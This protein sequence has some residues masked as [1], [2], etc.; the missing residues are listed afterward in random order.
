M[1]G[2][3]LILQAHCLSSPPCPLLH[4]SFYLKLTGRNCLLSHPVLLRYNGSPDTRFSPGTTRLMSW[5]D[6]QC[7]SRPL[8][9]LVVSLLSL[10]STLLFSRTG[11]VLSHRNS[12]THRQGRRLRACGHAAHARI[13]DYNTLSARRVSRTHARWCQALLSVTS[14]HPWH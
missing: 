12:L 9:A 7:Y 5:P 1:T 4:L 11:G 6:G 10:V 13:F 14:S 2:S 3:Y 8:Q